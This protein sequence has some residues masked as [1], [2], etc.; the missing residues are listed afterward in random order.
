MSIKN[1]IYAFVISLVSIVQSNASLIDRDPSGVA[2][3]K[4]LC[5]RALAERIEEEANQFQEVTMLEVRKSL[6]AATVQELTFGCPFRPDLPL[7]PIIFRHMSKVDLSLFDGL[8]E[9]LAQNPKCFE[10]PGQP[11][12]ITFLNISFNRLEQ[13]VS[14][15]RFLTSLT[16]LNVGH[17]NIGAH[18]SSLW[19]LTGLTNLDIW[20]NN[21]GKHVTDL[22]VFTSLTSLDVGNNKLSAHVCALGDLTNLTSL[23]AWRNDIGEHVTV[24]RCLPELQI[25]DVS[26]NKLCRHVSALAPLT[27]LISLEVGHNN[28]PEQD[29]TIQVLRARGVQVYL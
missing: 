14:T 10:F 11:L 23:R 24:L 29:N 17:N 7:Q 5:G 6:S 19:P 22:R 2:P 28:I 9:Y 21:L 12:F 4:R 3:L 18:V 27:R 26:D 25:L 20:D 1:P 16:S 8:T 13:Q 15:L